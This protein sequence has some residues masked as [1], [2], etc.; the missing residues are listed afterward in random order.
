MSKFMLGNVFLL[1]SMLLTSASQILIKELVDQA[2]PFQLSWEWLRSFTTPAMLLRSGV[3]AATVGAGLGCW[4][5]CLTRLNLSYA[6]PIACTSV[7][8]VTFFS[9]Y[10]LGEAITFRT[11]LGTGLIVAGIVLLIPAE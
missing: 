1:L 6:Y 11:W 3:A 8:L 9:A 4:L 7:L 2:Q 5:L 10:F